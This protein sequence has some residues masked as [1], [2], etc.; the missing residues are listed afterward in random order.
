VSVVSPNEWSTREQTTMAAAVGQASAVA[1][2]SRCNRRFTTYHSCR[3]ALAWQLGVHL[4]DFVPNSILPLYASDPT[5]VFV[6]GAPPHYV[7]EL[8]RGRGWRVVYAGDR[9][10]TGSCHLSGG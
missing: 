1:A 3:P 2:R 10:P 4:G 7:H 6:S 8:F 5:A 9:H